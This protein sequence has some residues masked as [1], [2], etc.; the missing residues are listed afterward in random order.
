M[1]LACKEAELWENNI[2]GSSSRDMRYFLYIGRI[3]EEES[4]S[5]YIPPP[6]PMTILDTETRAIIKVGIKKH[7][8]ELQTFFKWNPVGNDYI[9]WQDG[10]VYYSESVE[11]NQ[12][13]QITDGGPNMVHGTLDL[14]HVDKLLGANT[15]SGERDFEEQGVGWSPK[16]EKV[17]I[18][19][20]EVSSNEK[21]VHMISYF[22]ERNYAKTMEIRY[23][24]T[25]EFLP[26]HVISIWDKQTRTLK[27]MK[28]QLK[29]E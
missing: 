3:T 7:G 25:H 28:A 26:R 11:S 20:H 24:K 17:A 4:L 15:E 16:G 22:I 13:V 29:N 23:P 27:H 14:F 8:R 6:A 19:S 1:K 10:H 18:M 21:T 12:S 9:F 5:P 2:R